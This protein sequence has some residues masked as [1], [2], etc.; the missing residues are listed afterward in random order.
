MTDWVKYA[1]MIMVAAIAIAPTVATA[2][3]SQPTI[4]LKKTRSCGCC[5]AWGKRMQSAGFVVRS[6]D[7]TTGGLMQFKMKHGIRSNFA[8][9]TARIAGYTIEGHV[10]EREIRRLLH[11]KP[12][13]IGLSVPGMPLGSP[14]MD[15]GK[16]T[17]AYDVFLVRKDASTIPYAHYPA[18]E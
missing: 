5:A 3:Q 10:P 12:D 17:D 2:Q 1:V 15:F 9:H 7:M 11:E 4:E 14:G 16:S 8:C 18:K 6:E 13:A